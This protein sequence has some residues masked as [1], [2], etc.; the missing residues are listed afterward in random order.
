MLPGGEVK[1]VGD[2]TL[3]HWIL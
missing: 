1:T 3:P 2:L